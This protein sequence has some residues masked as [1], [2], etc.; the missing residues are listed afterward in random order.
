MFSS[1]VIIIVCVF[2]TIY[3]MKI[4]MPFLHHSTPHHTTLN[5]VFKRTHTGL[6]NIFTYSQ[7]DNEFMMPHCLYR[8]FVIHMNTFPH[9][10]IYVWQG[11][12]V[13]LQ[14]IKRYRN[15]IWWWFLLSF[16]SFIWKVIK[17]ECARILFLL[18]LVFLVLVLIYVTLCLFFLYFFC[19]LWACEWICFCLFFY[20]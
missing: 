17:R 16:S 18:F 3:L 6:E 1:F 8:V 12:V 10:Y 11:M 9:I 20:Y 7:P 19:C 5:I 14:N 4:I 2:Y 15:L 13:C